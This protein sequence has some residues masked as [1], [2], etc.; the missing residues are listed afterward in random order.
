MNTQKFEDWKYIAKRLPVVAWAGL[1]G[2]FKQVGPVLLLFLAIAFAYG[3]GKGDNSSWYLLVSVILGS[4]A[5]GSAEDRA[6]NRASIAW[7]SKFWNLIE[8][9]H[10]LEISVTHKTDKAA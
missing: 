4:F 2:A 8:T 6:E 5:I 10:V 3:I 1:R 9:D 7:A